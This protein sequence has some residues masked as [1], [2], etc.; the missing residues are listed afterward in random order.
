MKSVNDKS[1]ENK[2]NIND[3]NIDSYSGSIKIPIDL[4]VFADLWF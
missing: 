1:N 2:F 3:S 4:T